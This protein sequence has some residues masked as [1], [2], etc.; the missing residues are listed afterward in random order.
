[1]PEYKLTWITDHLAVGYAPMS[2]AELDSIKEQGISAIVNLCG[3]FCDLHEIEEKSGFEVYYLPIPDEDAPDMEAMEKA[4]EW[5]DEAIYLGKKV[6]IHC[7]HGVGRTGTF[8]TAYLIRRGL[9]LKMAEKKLK[10]TRANPTNYS[11]WRLLKKYGKK[12][13]PLKIREP[14][15]ESRDVVDLG[16]FFSDYEAVLRKADETADSIAPNRLLCGRDQHRC[17]GKYFELELIEAVYLSNT[18]NR[19]LRSDQRK[20][21]ISRALEVGKKMQK[22]QSRDQR[23]FQSMGLLCPLLQEDL[24]ILFENRPLR[25]RWDQVEVPRQEIQ[26]V[27]DTVSSISRTMFFTLTGSFLP[28]GLLSFSV[29]E[30]VSGRFVQKYFHF[31]AAHTEEQ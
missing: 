7:R 12:E 17:C 28:K 4:L 31:L 14:R 8:V 19:K 3:E 10:G 18:M 13:V 23:Q 29:A 11:Q 27:L 1:M 9:A 20:E 22:I 26:L 25:C 15:L 24:C 30:T 2:Y 5:L 6:L 16:P 21:V